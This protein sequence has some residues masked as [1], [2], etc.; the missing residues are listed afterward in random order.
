MTFPI[1]LTRTAAALALTLTACAD[2]A[3]DDAQATNSAPAPESA[4]QFGAPLS[5]AGAEAAV[6][7]PA[8]RVSVAPA[9]T[10]RI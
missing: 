5:V 10:C 3:D 7:S 2:S 9:K 1:H 6:A 4:A 8:P